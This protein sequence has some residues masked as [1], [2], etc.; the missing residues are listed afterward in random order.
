MKPIE[1]IVQ[2]LAQNPAIVW[3]KI[4]VA[5]I[6]KSTL[7]VLG[8]ITS[9]ALVVWG[10]VYVTDNITI[11]EQPPQNAVKTPAKK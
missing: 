9:V 8:K 10:V 2:R 3:V 4:D 1:N 5:D 6:V 11:V 7:N